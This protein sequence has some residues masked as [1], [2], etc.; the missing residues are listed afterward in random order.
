[1]TMLGKSRTTLALFAG[2]SLIGA[3]V[4]Y[5]SSSPVVDVS[6]GLPLA[7]AMPGAAAVE[8]TGLGWRLQFGE[9]AVWSVVVSLALDIAGGLLLNLFGGLT[10]AHWLLYL[11]SAV[12]V[13]CVLGAWRP[14]KES[15]SDAHSRVRLMEASQ[16]TIND[17]RREGA[18]WPWE[19]LLYISAVAM[20]VGALV[21]AELTSSST[22]ERFAELSLSPAP[23]PA[24]SARLEIGNLLGRDTTFGV[25]VYVVRGTKH[26][27]LH[28]WEVRVSS[29]ASWATT[30]ARPVVGTLEATLR[31][32]PGTGKS[33]LYVTLGPAAERR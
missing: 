33:P 32:Q 3:A 20:I 19:A 9:R 1:V 13:A 29:N 5:L 8:A 31:D 30:I 15:Q 12:L 22:R 16:R 7:L 18:R 28:S 4:C 17:H 23:S 24:R 25:R 6:F 27:E 2:A 26:V 21:V 14:P 11:A 10:R